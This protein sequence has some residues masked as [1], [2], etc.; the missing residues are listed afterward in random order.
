ME[1]RD[2]PYE[3]S[4]QATEA[5]GAD[6]RG[7]SRREFLKVAAVTGGAIGAAGGL[8]GLITAC[9]SAE[10]TT[11]T[12]ALASYDHHGPRDHHYRGAGLQHHSQQ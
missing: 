7:L 2:E 4:D 5:D 8:A 3:R 6:R 1:L 9:G 11:T 12:A 10:T